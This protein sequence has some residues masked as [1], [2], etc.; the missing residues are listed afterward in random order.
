MCR[1]CVRRVGIVSAVQPTA[2]TD[3][4][5]EPPSLSLPERSS[6]STKRLAGSLPLDPREGTSRLKIGA[7][8]IATGEHIEAAEVGVIISFFSGASAGYL[9][10]LN[11]R[12]LIR[13]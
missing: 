13:N 1:I 8:D 2:R 9:D 11:F 10:I 4:A 3:Q 6:A 7:L 5:L 12:I